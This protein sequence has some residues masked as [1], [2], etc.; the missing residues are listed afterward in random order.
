MNMRFISAEKFR[1]RKKLGWR[2]VRFL[3]TEEN[4]NSLNM[5]STVDEIKNVVRQERNTW[6][7]V[8]IN[9]LLLKS[10]AWRQDIFKN[11]LVLSEIEISLCEIDDILWTY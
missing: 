11:I 8:L 4:G 3:K 9:R 2:V 1:E 5:C 10:Q 6:K 7:F